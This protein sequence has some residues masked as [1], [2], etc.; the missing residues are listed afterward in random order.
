MAY[1]VESIIGFEFPPLA[2]EDPDTLTYY[3]DM[4]TARTDQTFFG[5]EYN[6]AIAL[7]AI[8]TYIMVNDPSRSWGA[9]GLVIGK[10]EGRNSIRYWNSVKTGGSDLQG[11]SFGQR[12]KA[13]MI[14]KRGG[15][16]SASTRVK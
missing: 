14:A 12:L 2:G 3:I 5:N 1:D 6:L 13:L 8:H 7:R 10:S 15:A 9:A 16:L 4:A 11:T